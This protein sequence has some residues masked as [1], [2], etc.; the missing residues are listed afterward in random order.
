MRF[1]LGQ[2]EKTA[3][4]ENFC[5]F[6]KGEEEHKD[7][8]SVAGWGVAKRGGESCDNLLLSYWRQSIKGGGGGGDGTRGG[9]GGKGGSGG[10][11]VWRGPDMHSRYI[12]L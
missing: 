8:K 6:G 10:G 9:G 1:Y 2:P 7:P 11:G 3:S 4:G 5:L 12:V